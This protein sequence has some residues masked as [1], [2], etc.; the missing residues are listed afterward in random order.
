MS[1][2]LVGVHERI[3]ALVMPPQPVERLTLDGL[4][5]VDDTYRTSSS[6]FDTRISGLAANLRGR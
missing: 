3:D 6:P 4:I 1:A 5:D 2:K